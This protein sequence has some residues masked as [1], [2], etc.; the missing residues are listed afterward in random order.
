M[1]KEVSILTILSAQD[2]AQRRAGTNGVSLIF[3]PHTM[4]PCASSDGTIRLPVPKLPMEYEDWIKYKAAL[5]HEPLHIKRKELFDIIS[6]W[7]LSSDH[8]LLR[9]VNI[10]E[11]SVMERLHLANYYGDRRD[12]AEAMNVI[13]REI[14]EYFDANKDK[15]N[16]DDIDNA[17]FT[18]LS[19]IAVNERKQWHPE[20]VLQG[21]LLEKYLTDKAK[22]IVD[23]VTNSG[24]L[25]RW[26]K[27]ESVEDS[28]KIGKELY[29]LVYDEPEKA[30]K[31]IKQAQGNTKEQQSGSQKAEADKREKEKQEL[32]NGKIP[33]HLLDTSNHKPDN[34]LL[35]GGGGVDWKGKPLD[36]GNYVY[37]KPKLVNKTSNTTSTR[38]IFNE[39]LNVGLANE[40]RRLIQAK[41]RVNIIPEKLSGKLN[42]NALYRVAIPLRDGD[43]NFRVFKKKDDVKRIDTAVSVLVDWS[44]SM[45]T[46]KKKPMAVQ[47]VNQCNKIFSKIINIPLEVAAFTCGSSVPEHL[48]IKTFDQRVTDAE[49]SAKFAFFDM[50]SAGNADADSLVYAATR[51][52]QRKEKRKIILVLSDGMPSAGEGDPDAALRT[53]IRDLTA[54]GIEVYGIGLEDASVRRYYGK[55]VQVVTNVNELSPAL[56]NTFKEKIL[57][58]CE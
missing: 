34:G 4:V 23:R 55:N 27:A 1:N 49:V 3:D 10:V 8:P 35:G 2:E 42:K 47:A 19:V 31:E 20:S 24:L 14:L 54:S 30:D 9:T 11:D 56:L 29:D 18:A 52:M 5:I 36:Y 28:A 32:A 6:K 43:W 58:V 15:I 38:Y 40:I 7:N 13:H 53:V 22:K 25:D 41:Q 46:G 39:Q 37:T 48:I 44:G 45:C 26:L 50:H 16:D 17:R 12:M 57:G 51:I 33:W 21:S